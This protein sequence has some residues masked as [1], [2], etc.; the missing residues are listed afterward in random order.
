MTTAQVVDTSVIV[1][2]NSSIQDYVHHDDQTQPTF[3][4]SPLYLNAWNK[5]EWLMQYSRHL[6]IIQCR[7][8]GNISGGARER[9]RRELLG[10][11]WGHGPPENFEI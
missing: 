5:L 8:K 3:S 7:S 1:N 2:N 11:V 6:I 10:G 4:H 9:R